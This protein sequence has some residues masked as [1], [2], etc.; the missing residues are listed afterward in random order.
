MQFQKTTRKIAMKYRESFKPAT[1]HVVRI[2]S[3]AIFRANKRR[4]NKKGAEISAPQK[5]EL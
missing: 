3:T 1:T 2:L 4:R 5:I